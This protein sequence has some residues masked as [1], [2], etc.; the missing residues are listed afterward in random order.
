[1]RFERPSLVTQLSILSAAGALPEDTACF[2]RVYGMR[3]DMKMK[4][5]EWHC[6]SLQLR[7]RLQGQGLSCGHAQQAMEQAEQVSYQLKLA[8]KHVYP[9]EGAGN[10][11]AFET[12]IEHA[13][14]QYWHALRGRFD[15]LLDQFADLPTDAE[16]YEPALAACRAWWEG[17]V[18]K[19]G[20]QALN[21]AIG[22]LDTDAEALQQHQR[23]ED[24]S[25]EASDSYF[26]PD[27]GTTTKRRGKSAK[28]L[29][30][31]VTQ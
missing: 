20:W 12:L 13:Q 26:T 22:D 3:T 25:T 7:M 11:A 14:R 6:E 8:V 10:K 24:N 15:N 18:G 31:E 27:N 4:V 29:N 19:V 2:A 23:R 28:T 1:M 16:A 17:A 9:R 21:D 5:F 30:E